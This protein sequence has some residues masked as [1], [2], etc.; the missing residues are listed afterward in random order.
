[1]PRWGEN[2]DLFASEL[3]RGHEFAV[4]IGRRFRT[5]GLRAEVTASALAKTAAARARFGRT[6]VDLIV[7]GRGGRQVIE[8]KSRRIRFSG[9]DDWPE[10]FDPAMVDTVAGWQTKEH[11]PVAV[12]LVSQY[13]LGAAVV[14]ASSFPY[15][16]IVRK[17]DA[18]REIPT[19]SYAC[20]AEHLRSF[21]ELCDW[22]KETG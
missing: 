18:R 11:R 6:D 8:I 13:T 1:M 4:V 12:V 19:V 7:Y 3:R 9:P 16:Q 14:P 15:W 22:M 17:Q 5:A 21:S 10:A 20:P 2:E